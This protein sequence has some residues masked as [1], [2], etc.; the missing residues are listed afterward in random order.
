M[1]GLT[2]VLHSSQREVDQKEQKTNRT[3]HTKLNYTKLVTDYAKGIIYTVIAFYLHY[4]SVILRD[5]N[6]TLY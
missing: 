6:I 5:F 2:F 4:Y 1:W 3:K